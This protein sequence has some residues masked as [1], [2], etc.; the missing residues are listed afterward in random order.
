MRSRRGE[1]ILSRVVPSRG[2]G[3]ARSSLCANHPLLDTYPMQSIGAIELRDNSEAKSC[4]KQHRFRDIVNWH[5]VEFHCHT[6]AHEP[7]L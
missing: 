1:Q 4:L 3:V 5:L 2:G 6:A 7:S